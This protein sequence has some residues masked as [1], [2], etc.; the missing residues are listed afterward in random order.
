MQG[1]YLEDLHVQK[2]FSVYCALDSIFLQNATN[3]SRERLECPCILLVRPNGK[4]SGQINVVDMLLP[5]LQV[6]FQQ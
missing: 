3:S 4:A 1:A 2:P 5:A 6:P